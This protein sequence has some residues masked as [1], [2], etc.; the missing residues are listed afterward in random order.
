VQAATATF[1][2][3]DRLALVC[4]RPLV[5]LAFALL[6]LLLPNSFEVYANL[7][8]AQWH[9]AL[10]A[11]L[12]CVSRSPAG[13][14]GRI[15]DA[16]ILLLSGLSGP[17]CV[18]LLP[19][20]LLV[21]ATR[22]D[23]A[24][25]ERA[26][27]VAFGAATQLWCLF[28]NG[29]SRA[30]PVLGAGPRRLGL[31]LSMQVVLPLLLGRHSTSLYQPWPLWQDGLLPSVVA[32]IAAALTVRAVLAGPP[33]ARLSCLFA[34]LIMLAA[35]VRPAIGSATPAWIGMSMPDVGDRYYMLPMLGW[36]VVLF[37]LA[38]DLVRLFRWTARI[39]LL[40]T[41]IMLPGDWHLPTSFPIGGRND[42]IAR[43]DAFAVAPTGTEMQF[44]VHPEGMRPMILRQTGDR[45]VKESF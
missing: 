12:V 28:G 22:R 39:L 1:L 24:S 37:V 45:P 11:F 2:L 9:L 26:A 16:A 43:A 15:G 5:R 21:A 44:P 31:I 3:S 40:L 19:V 14:A 41:A 27:L 33:V 38:A 32:L 7:T 17:C 6:Y 35:L 18:F 4:P 20:S 42:F 34:G 36:A 25:V 29:A 8:N 30:A 13:I 10:L 23:R